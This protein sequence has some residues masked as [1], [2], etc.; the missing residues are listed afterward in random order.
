MFSIEIQTS[1]IVV[2]TP[3]G[4]STTIPTQVRD[5]RSEQRKTV[6]RQGRPIADVLPF[7]AF[8]LLDVLTPEPLSI[9]KTITGLTVRVGERTMR[10]AYLRS[11]H[12]LL[13]LMVV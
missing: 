12:H 10:V 3:H 11:H 2:T 7:A 6:Q 13:S 4:V 5:L 9:L 1:N 8:I